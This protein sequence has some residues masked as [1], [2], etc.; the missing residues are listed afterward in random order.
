MDLT[1][2][3]V[4]MVFWDFVGREQ[5]GGYLRLL[6]CNKSPPAFPAESS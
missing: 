3:A 1:K 2:S 5:L 4:T 6:S